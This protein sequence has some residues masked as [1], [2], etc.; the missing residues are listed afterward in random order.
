MASEKDI[1]LISMAEFKEFMYHKIVPL[2]DLKDYKGE[3]LEKILYFWRKKEL[4]PF[5][6]KGK[7]AQVSFANLIWFRILDLLRQFNFPV[8]HVKKVCDYFFKDAYD[9]NLPEINLRDNIV[10]YERKKVAGTISDDELA[11]L[12]FMKEI[13]A[14]EAF[15]HILKLDINYLTMLVLN[16]LDTRVDRGILVFLDGRIAEFDGVHHGSH[17]KGDVI[18]PTEPHIYISIIYLLRDFI[19]STHLSSLVVP[20]LLNEDERMVLREL[21]AKNLQTLTVSFQEG[22]PTRFDATEGGTLS[23]HQAQ[24]IKELLGLDNY[25]QIELKTRTQKVLSFKRTRKHF[26]KD[27]D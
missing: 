2:E 23:E 20:Q 21:K 5:I 27:S 7:K 18:D 1:H 16:C 8:V 13:L 26:I 24:Q 25:E 10:H 3:P 14:D 9:N 15:K 12:A 17:R 4:I 6:P 11:N 22:R 19:K